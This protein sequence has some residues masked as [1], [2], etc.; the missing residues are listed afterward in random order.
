M[1]KFMPEVFALLTAICWAMGSF[2]GKKGLHIAGLS[3][4]VGLIVRLGVSLIVVAIIAGTKLHEFGDAFATMNGKKGLLYLFIFEGLIA[5]SFGMIFYY[6]AI[7]AG[8]LSKVMPIAF[9]TPL[10]GFLLAVA[11]AGEQ[12]TIMKS[13]GAGLAILGIIILTIA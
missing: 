13:T 5:G 6:R 7:K 4:Q 2:F 9:T 1:D 3:P 8:Q 12:V 10:W 11:F